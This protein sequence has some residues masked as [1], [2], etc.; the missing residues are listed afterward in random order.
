MCGISFKEASVNDFDQ[1]SHSVASRVQYVQD[2][3]PE[4]GSSL[5]C[6]RIPGYLEWS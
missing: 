5:V 2:R 3:G 1:Y 6:S 4:A